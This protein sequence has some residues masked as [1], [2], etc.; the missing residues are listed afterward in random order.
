VN[1]PP[2]SP[3][4]TIDCLRFSVAN[5]DAGLAFYRDRLGLALVWRTEEAAG[6]RLPGTHTEIVLHCEALAPEI[7][8]K[9][10]SA[11]AAAAWFEEAGGKVVVPPFDIAIGRAVVVQDPWGNEYVLLDASKGMFVTDAAGHIIGHADPTA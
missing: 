1:A 8:F 4:H 3:L 6:L 7:D 9:V 10:A 11:D 2:T 5:L